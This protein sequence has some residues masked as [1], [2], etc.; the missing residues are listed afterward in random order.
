MKIDKA[1][2][3]VSNEQKKTMLVRTLIVG[4]ISL[5]LIAGIVLRLFQL[6]IL[7]HERYATRAT[8]NRLVT[9]PLAPAR[10]LVFDRNGSVLAGNKQV[11]SL[12]VVGEN[13][14]DINALLTRVREILS[15]DADEEESFRKRL[16]NTSR[17]GEKV[18]LKRHLNDVELATFA[19]NRFRHPELSVTTETLRDYPMNDLMAHVVGSV[20]QITTEDLQRL[21]PIRYGAT[22]FIGR[23]GV[24]K[25]YEDAL[26]GQVGYRTVEVNVHG[27]V[28]RE[29]T[30]E[31]PARGRTV[32]LHIDARLQQVADEALG[33]RRG[34]VVAIDPKTGGILT[35]VSKPTYDPNG[36]VM[37]M[38]DRAYNHLINRRDTPLFNRATQ[39]TYPPGST[40]KPI[41]ALACLSKDLVDWDE[42]IMD[43]T[44]EFQLPNSSQVWRDWFQHQSGR[45]QG[46]INMYRAIYRSSNV[47]FYEMSTRLDVDELAQFANKFGVG[48]STA[49]DVADAVDGLMPTKQWKRETKGE[50]WYRGD[51]VN[52]FI[53]QGDILVTPLQMATFATLLANRGEWIRPRLL[54]SSDQ[55]IELDE[56]FTR[57]FSPIEDPSEADW[58]LM[59]DALRAVIHRG[60]Q[61]YLQNG[62]AWA[63]IGMNIPYLMA[64]KSG[65]VQVVGIPHGDDIVEEPLEEHKQEHA[66]FFG[67]APVEDPVIAV[68]VVIENGAADGGGGSSVAG[69]VVRSVIDAYLGK[70]VAVTGE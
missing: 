58:F 44:G 22:M 18:I 4:A 60:N 57:S 30:S 17:P 23:R 43:I 47:F 1:R 8:D 15:F 54:M 34:A 39:G 66:L 32:T 29:L 67:F 37:G 40:F 7:N 5:V 20:R 42:E 61:G 31:P 25:F 70:S 26:H 51:N 65:T 45:G 2:L 38:T 11:Q 6:Q 33:D 49:I 50:A 56:A 24:E 64:G 55:P 68:A 28:M 3:Q 14:D 59:V 63:H 9:Q 35:L 13:I 21:D 62:I 46:A 12:S 52:L 53:G 69:P 41:V 27:R 48:R 36:F 19:V 16:K 10:G